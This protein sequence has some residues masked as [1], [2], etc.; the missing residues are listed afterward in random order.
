MTNEDS[1]WK[2]L[3]AEWQSGKEMLPRVERQ[4][5]SRRRRYVAQMIY[6][7]SVLLVALGLYIHRVYTDPSADVAVFGIVAIA[8]VGVLLG[9]LL[10]AWKD[11][12]APDAQ[13]VAAYLT[14]AR[15]QLVSHR[16]QVLVGSW[17]GG[18]LGVFAILWLLWVVPWTAPGFMESA[19]GAIHVAVLVGTVVLL[20]FSVFYTRRTM[21]RLA[22]ELRCLDELEDVPGG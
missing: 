14:A 22:S 16:R 13:S 6:V 7:G 9:F 8:I 18:G 1:A 21:R 4:L 3:A 10:G 11:F 20:V 2:E 17:C 15:Y 12:R 5:S 19:G